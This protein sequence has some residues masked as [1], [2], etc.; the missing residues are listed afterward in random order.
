MKDDMNI[1]F[2]AFELVKAVVLLFRW[3]T[4]MIYAQLVVVPTLSH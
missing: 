1:E 2:P 4:S 3:Q